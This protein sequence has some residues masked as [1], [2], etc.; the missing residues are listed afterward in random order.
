MNSDAIHYGKNPDLGTY[1]DDHYVRCARCGFI[2]NTDR[3]LKGTGMMGWGTTQPNTLL[4]GAVLAAATTIT[5]D[6]T[7]G[8]T[9][10][11][12]I[13]IYDSSTATGAPHMN[14]VTYTG[15]TGTTFTGCTGATAHDD[16]MVVRGD[17]V[18][19]GCPQCGTLRYNK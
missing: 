12:Y 11:G 10:T 14:K 16:N 8:F 2:C 6:S 18:N 3:D 5:V 15:L 7:T 17:Q 13:Y 1:R 19:T 4:N 9:S